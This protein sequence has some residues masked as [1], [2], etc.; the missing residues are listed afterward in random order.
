MTKTEVSGTNLERQFKAPS[1][2]PLESRSL[3]KKVSSET[4]AKNSASP[5]FKPNVIVRKR[6]HPAA[7]QL[8]IQTSDQPGLQGAPPHQN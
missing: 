3:T 6:P 5:K 8:T 1:R 2:Q 4:S 7:Q